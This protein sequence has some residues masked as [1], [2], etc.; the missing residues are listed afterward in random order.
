[1]TRNTQEEYKKRIR[2]KFE[3][4]KNG[5]YTDVFFN[6]SRA[7]LRKLCF[8]LFKDNTNA[9]DLKSF[10]SFFKY[11]FSLDC[12]KK[13]KDDTDKFRPIENFLKGETEPADFE[14]INMAAILVD[15]QPRP[16]SKFFKKKIISEAIPVVTK[17]EINKPS[18]PLPDINPPLNIV[19]T[20]NKKRINKKNG[21]LLAAIVVL[22]MG[23]SVKH[24]FFANKQCMEWQKDHYVVV[25]CSS[26][27]QGFVRIPFDESLT[28]FR[29]IW[30]CDTTTFFK[31]GKAVL[32]YC[33]SGD[34]IELYNKPGF[35]P[36]YEKPL[37][38]IT[39]Y[40][41]NKYFK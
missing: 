39:E 30:P 3:T 29:R 16:F 9:D 8:E 36:V 20:T 7:K 14:T 38:P 31:D 26:E 35:D 10:E 17:T 18:V 13:L 27:T 5:V 34:E 41:I 23:F 21:I 24:I 15:F 40:M 28:D 6:P 12:G 37:R 4:E 25:D 2:E 32:W 1:M 33:K 11:K 19:N 22:G